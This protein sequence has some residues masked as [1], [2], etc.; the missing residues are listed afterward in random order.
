M[1]KAAVEALRRAIP[2]GRE[3]PKLLGVTILTS[4]DAEAMRAVGIA[5]KPLA[6][7]VHLARL[8]KKCGLDGV[9]TSTHEAAH[10]RRACGPGF[11]IV[12]GGVRPAS[13]VQQDDQSR[14]ATPAAAIR[15]GADYLVVGRPITGAK[16]PHSAASAILDEMGRALRIRV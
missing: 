8:A 15:A 7:A 16:N 13:H 6:R 14:V 5:G 12:V 9:V 2:K 3:R 4:M 10:I 1:M 11:I